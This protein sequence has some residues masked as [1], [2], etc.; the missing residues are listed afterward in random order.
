MAGLRLLNIFD[1]ARSLGRKPME[2]TP[3]SVAQWLSAEYLRKKGGRFNYDPSMRATYELFRGAITRDQ[4][5][6][7][8]ETHGSPAGH[9]QNAAAISVVAPYA[10]ANPS[11]CYK[12]SFT[13]VEVG[14]VEGKTI[15]AAIKAPMVRVRDG[16]AFVVVPGYRMGFRPEEIEIDV[17]CSIAM[18][19]LARD[20]FSRA[21]F[22]YLYAGPGK[23]DERDFRVIHGRERNVFDR[24]A[25][26][27][28]L[29][30][31]VKGVALAAQTGP[32][33]QPPRLAGYRVVDKDQPSAF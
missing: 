7:Y 8:C 32:H 9:T 10:L 12:I 17:A 1:I 15:Y 21:D 28:L 6:K 3:E 11:T 18:A 22:E 33:L 27:S 25:V 24:D 26:D 5:A 19:H 14:R 4:A 23:S 13:A 20:D 16:R 29:D 31:Y 30:I 2:T